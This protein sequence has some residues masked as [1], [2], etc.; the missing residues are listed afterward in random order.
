MGGKGKWTGEGISLSSYTKEFS[1]NLARWVEDFHGV[2]VA[3]HQG[4]VRITTGQYTRNLRD[5]G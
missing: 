4:R 5:L 3:H 1:S 2:T